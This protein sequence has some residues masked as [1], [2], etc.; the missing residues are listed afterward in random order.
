[1]YVA[2]MR[3]ISFQTRFT[4]TGGVHGME[5]GRYFAQNRGNLTRNTAAQQL[6]RGKLNQILME[7]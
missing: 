1:M 7:S 4:G 3:I 2:L 5:Q 6:P